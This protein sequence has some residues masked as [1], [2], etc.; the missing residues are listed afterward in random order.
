MKGTVLGGGGDDFS[1]MTFFN[2]VGRLVSHHLVIFRLLVH[3]LNLLT[4][5]LIFI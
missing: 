5:P 3:H 4:P 2:P 1:V